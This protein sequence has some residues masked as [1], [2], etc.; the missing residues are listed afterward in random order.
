MSE[1]PTTAINDSFSFQ[2]IPSLTMFAF[3]EVVPSLG[4]AESVIDLFSGSIRTG[5]NAW[6][7]SVAPQNFG[8]TS[9]SLELDVKYQGD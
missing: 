3:G 6:L 7:L 8:R 9:V 2:G 1:I 4:M 5:V